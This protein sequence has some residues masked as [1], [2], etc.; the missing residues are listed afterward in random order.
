MPAEVVGVYSV[1]RGLR[2]H[3]TYCRSVHLVTTIDQ[4]ILLDIEIGAFYYCGDPISDYIPVSRKLITGCYD[5]RIS[6][7]NHG[8][9][10]RIG[11][12]DC[13]GIVIS[14]QPYVTVPGVQI[15]DNT[16]HWTVGNYTYVD[17]GA[18]LVVMYFEVVKHIAY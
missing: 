1:P 5:V 13:R 11:Y 14:P 9:N 3:Y 6:A 2:W 15:T 18:W 16:Y 17:I 4:F 8:S 7:T 12:T 10:V